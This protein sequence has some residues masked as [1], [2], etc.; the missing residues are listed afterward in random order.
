MSIMAAPGSTDNRRQ[1][2][3]KSHVKYWGHA[4]G[5]KAVQNPIRFFC[6]RRLESGDQASV[7]QP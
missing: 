4:P 6:R 5:T 3:I 7:S 1:R 2:S